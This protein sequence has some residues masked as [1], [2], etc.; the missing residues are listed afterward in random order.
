MFWLCNLLCNNILKEPQKHK[1]EAIADHDHADQN[2]YLMVAKFNTSSV[3]KTFKRVANPGVDSVCWM[4]A[5][6]HLV[7]SPI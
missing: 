2:F 5:G 3:I 7:T 1:P 4:D 6:S